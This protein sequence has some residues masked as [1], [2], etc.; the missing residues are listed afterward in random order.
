[1]NGDERMNKKKSGKVKK[2][3]VHYLIKLEKKIILDKKENLEFNKEF[4]LKKKE[5]KKTKEW[6]L[7][8]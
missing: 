5:R 1:M 3:S 8:E 2:R 6:K 4:Q 7:D